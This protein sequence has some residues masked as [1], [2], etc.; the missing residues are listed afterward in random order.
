MSFCLTV[1][2]STGI[3]LSSQIRLNSLF[4]IC[5]FSPGIINN[6]KLHDLYSSELR[7]SHHF[8]TQYYQYHYLQHLYTSVEQTSPL[9]L[10]LSCFS[11]SSCRE[12]LLSVNNLVNT[13]IA[14]VLPSP[15]TTAPP[16]IPTAQVTSSQIVVCCLNFTRISKQVKRNLQLTDKQLRHWAIIKFIFNVL[17]CSSLPAT[18]SGNKSARSSQKLKTLTRNIIDEFSGTD[19]MVDVLEVVLVLESKGLYYYTLHNLSFYKMLDA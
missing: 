15:P 4:F 3:E 1:D 11:V 16:P 14:V 18:G 10:V 2:L 9:T 19:I 12:L 5:S 13:C 7:H 6:L 8:Q 17:K